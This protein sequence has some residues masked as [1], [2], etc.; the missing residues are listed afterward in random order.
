M[1]KCINVMKVMG[2]AGAV[3]G[4]GY[5]FWRGTYSTD[6]SEIP[7]SETIILLPMCGML[8]GTFGAVAGGFVGATAPISTPYL[9]YVYDKN[10]N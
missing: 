4:G 8:T 9:I 2:G 7:N 3:L 10:K 1:N 5:G 6:F